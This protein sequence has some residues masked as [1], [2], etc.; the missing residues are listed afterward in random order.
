[1]DTSLIF[2]WV[3]IYMK[4]NIATTFGYTP[5]NS[6]LIPITQKVVGCEEETIE[7]PQ[8]PMEVKLTIN[9]G[10]QAIPLQNMFL[11]S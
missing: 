8:N 2:D 5:Q 3:T 9:T 7:V 11:S 4:I 1:M 6:L 10:P